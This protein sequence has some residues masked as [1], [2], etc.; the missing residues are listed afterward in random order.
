MTYCFY[1]TAVTSTGFTR[2]SGFFA[3]NDGD[4]EGKYFCLFWDNALKDH[5]P[6]IDIFF[7]HTKGRI[8]GNIEIRFIFYIIGLIERNGIRKTEL[9]KDFRSTKEEIILFYS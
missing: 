5:I 9:R 8:F 3:S 6:K 2:T 4:D 7:L 1:R